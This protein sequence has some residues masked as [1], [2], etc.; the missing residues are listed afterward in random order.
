MKL[1]YKMLL[2]VVVTVLVFALAG[3]L[4]TWAPDR[5]LSD[6]VPRWA[7][8]PSGF[9]T[10]NGIQVHFRD[11][12]PRDDPLP[13][14]LL[15]GTSASLHTW[16]GWVDALK[17]KRRVIRFDLP[18]FGL[19]GPHTNNDY[20]VEADVRM[21][22]ALADNLGVKTFVV[23]GNSLGGEIAWATAYALPQRVQRLVLIDAAGYPI[24]PQSIPVGFRIARV[25]GLRS[26]AELVLPRGVIESSL[27]SVYGD[28]GKVTPVLVDRYYELTLRE[29]NRQALAY[30]FDQMLK[31]DSA[32][33]IAAIQS[34]KL[35]TLIIWGG[36]DK[37]IPV[38][39]GHRF[40]SDIVGS[41][42]VVLEALGHVPQ[43]EDPVG[44]LQVVR[45][46]LE[47]SL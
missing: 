29:G 5:K 31:A 3:V 12:G 36:K 43:E 21:V 42:L 44:T 18:G 25:P 10:L 27:R 33:N 2:V 16:D 41:Q 6:L 28:P 11:E 17:D 45:K 47:A 37:L 26:L 8:A 7:Q 23:A 4:A 34:L 13:L 24:A 38:E 30:R 19:T 15:H 35:P 39:N 46:F 1:L 40:A 14:I 20:S 32:K 9:V 22:E